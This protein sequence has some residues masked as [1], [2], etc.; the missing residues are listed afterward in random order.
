MKQNKETRLL[1]KAKET[2]KDY[3]NIRTCKF[4]LSQMTIKHRDEVTYLRSL[5]LDTVLQEEHWQI[6]VTSLR[7][8]RMMKD[9]EEK[10]QKEQLNKASYSGQRR[11]ETGRCRKPS[12]NTCLLL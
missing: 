6:G 10:T 5:I 9:L 3:S 4:V 2:L 1:W 7:G 12:R 11:D 8:N